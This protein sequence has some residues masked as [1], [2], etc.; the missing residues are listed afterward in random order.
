MDFA[1]I[2]ARNRGNIDYSQ[3]LDKIQE[4]G[5]SHVQSHF[6]NINFG[7]KGELNHLILDGKPPF[8]PLARELLKRK[9]DATIICES[10]IT[11]KDS[12]KM[13]EIFEGLG[14]EL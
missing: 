12:L 5:H 14:H 3:V 13:K 8:E 10:P 2:Y 1:H 9:L 11:W 4:A 6:S 7:L